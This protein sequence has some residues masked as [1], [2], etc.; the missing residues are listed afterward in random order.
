MI[1]QGSLHSYRRTSWK[2][3]RCMKHATKLLGGLTV[4][5][6]FPLTRWSDCRCLAGGA[7]AHNFTF[8]GVSVSSLCQALAGVRDLSPPQ[9]IESAWPPQVRLRVRTSGFLVFKCSPRAWTRRPVP[10]LPCTP[11]LLRWGPQYILRHLV[12]LAGSTRCS[13]SRSRWCL[14]SKVQFCAVYK[15]CSFLVWLSLVQ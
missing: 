15:L 13:C 3:Q 2:Q 7:G 11:K 5:R 10:N 1:K 8:E 12:A 14:N 4:S 6:I 9:L